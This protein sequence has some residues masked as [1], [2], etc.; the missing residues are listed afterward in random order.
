[1]LLSVLIREASLCSEQ[2]L[3]MAALGA[4]NKWSVGLALSK[5]FVPSLCS[6][7][8]TAKEGIKRRRA[9]ECHLLERHSHCS[10]DSAAAACTK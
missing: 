3:L 6:S 10:P 8:N 4:E 7:E 9:V 1:M 2:S 5:I